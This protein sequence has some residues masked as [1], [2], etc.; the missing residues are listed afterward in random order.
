VTA[1]RDV[2]EMGEGV[3]L[4][5]LGIELSCIDVQEHAASVA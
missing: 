3:K 1:A 5:G 2:H 4:V